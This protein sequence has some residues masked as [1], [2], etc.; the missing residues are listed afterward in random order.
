MR[1]YSYIVAFDDGFAPCAM[2][3]LCSLACCKPK[4]RRRAQEGDWVIGTTPKKRRARRLVYMMQVNR[5]PSLAD[6]YRDPKLRRRRDC[7]YR[8]IGRRLE[9][10]ENDA[11]G[12]ANIR[13]D[14]SGKYV[15]LSPRFVYFGREAPPIPPE[16]HK[17]VARTQGHRVWGT[18]GTKAPNVIQPRTLNSIVGW[19]FSKGRG[20]RGKPASSKAAK[21]TGCEH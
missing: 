11:H 14:L 3:G 13:K 17:Y 10:I 7:I 16:F 12:H 5:T 19:A 15:L 8:P 9:Q 6:Y 2:Q 18:P 21:H 1:L 4:I 20:V